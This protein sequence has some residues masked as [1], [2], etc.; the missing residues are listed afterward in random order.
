[1]RGTKEEGPLPP[2]RHLTEV[3]LVINTSYFKNLY[4]QNH[5]TFYENLW[6]FSLT[7]QC[8]ISKQL[9]FSQ[10]W[11]I[12]PTV[13]LSSLELEKKSL[14]HCFIRLILNKEFQDDGKNEGLPGVLGNKG[15]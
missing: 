8:L 4:S 1:M 11:H 6:F 12:I 3:H 5:D 13:E 14:N 2:R 9:C 7:K 10:K 15:T